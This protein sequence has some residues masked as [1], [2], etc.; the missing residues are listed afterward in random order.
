M[1]IKGILFNHHGT[2]VDSEATHFGIWQ[3]LLKKYNVILP[4]ANYKKYHSGTSTLRNA[5]ILV[6]HFNLSVSPSD[7]A[8]DKNKSTKV[9]L[10]TLKFPLMPF[11]RD[12]IE[13]F[14]AL[15]LKLGVVT[16]AGR[17]GVDS[18]LKG[19]KLEKYFDVVSTSE[20]VTK[21]KPDPGVYL[22]ALKQLGISAEGA[23]AIEDT[24]NGIK[25]AKAAGLIC[26]VVKNEFSASHDLSKADA[27]F[28]NMGEAKDWISREYCW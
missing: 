12:T 22:F 18:T 23:I 21:S 16:G 7:L 4:E 1:K 20:N 24:E 25:A 11:V 8:E 19:H 10:E 2:L 3:E 5:E 28:E 26:C 14:H 6:D 17:Y 13:Y 27:V 9:F 15:N